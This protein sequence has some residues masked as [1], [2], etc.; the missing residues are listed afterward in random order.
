MKKVTLCFI[1]LIFI[2][3]PVSLQAQSKSKKSVTAV[4]ES[5]HEMVFN[6]KGAQDSIVYLAIH[7]RDKLMLRDSARLQKPG[8]YIFK[9]TN[10]LDDGLYTLISQKK[11]PYLNFIIDRNQRFEYS[12]D[13]TYNTA[14]FSVINSPQNAE[15]LAFQQKTASAQLRVKEIQEKR[16]KFE[17]THQTDS[18]AYYTEQLQLVNKEMTD[19]IHNLIERNPDFLFSKL[20]KA[21]QPITI[22]DPPV[23]SDGSID[24][25]FQMVYYRTH[26]WDNVDLQDNRF[27]FL[28]VLEPMYNEYFTKVL[29][30]QEV[31]TVTHYI[32]IFLDKVKGDSLMYRYFLERLS[33]QF[34]TSK[35]LGHDAVFVHIVKNNHL[36]GKVNWL[37]PSTLKKYEKRINELDPL[38]IGKKGP[39]LIIADTSGKKWYSSHQ[40][41]DQYVILWFFDPTCH[42]CK[43]ESQK[44]KILYD[45]LEKAGTRN[46]EIYAIGNDSDENRWKRYVRDNNFPWINVGGHVANVDYRDAYNVMANPTMYILNEKREI[47]LNRRIDV[48]KIP[49]FISQYEKIEALKKNQ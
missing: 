35:L 45:S 42:T 16:K 3:I 7:Y 18:V 46:F 44:L 37:E 1:F 33:Y 31:D 17:N 24:S 4:A 5:G 15:M 39:E 27:I 48:D 47:I 36:Q 43:K 38:L 40:L 13:T 9:G 6:I 32:D 21:Y 25:N 30:Y 29:F 14:N 20:Q 28:P 49:E 22:P 26:F 34:E 2:Y 23:R 10:T 8:K 41:P 12:L 11:T 19:F